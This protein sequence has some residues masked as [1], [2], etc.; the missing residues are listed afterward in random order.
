MTSSPRLVLGRSHALVSTIRSL[1]RSAEQRARAGLLVAEGVRLAEEALKQP[2]SIAQAVVSARLSRDARGR[3]LLQGLRASGVPTRHA[4]DSLMASLHDAESHQ[5][6]LLLVRRRESSFD[7]PD[8]PE[9]RSTIVLLTCGLQD[10]GNVGALVRLVE[11]AGGWGLIA[12]GGADPFGPKA[13]RA[14][15][16]SIFRLPVLRLPSEADARG[17]ALSLQQRGLSLVAATARGGVDHRAARLA[18]PVV[19]LLGS[20]AAG[21]P[22]SILNIVD[23][24][25]TIPVAHPVE[26]LNVAAAAAVLLFEAARPTPRGMVARSGPPQSKGSRAAGRERRGARSR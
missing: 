10:P 1:S 19:L 4:E 5:G 11:A 13:A 6:V 2:T 16:G 15:A 17:M 21:L 23:E 25:V 12:A 14:S 18:P 22:G 7:A 26:S 24:R 8:P 20:E 3:K 9:G